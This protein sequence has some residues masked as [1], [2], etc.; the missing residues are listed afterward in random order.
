MS[1]GNGDYWNTPGAKAAEAAAKASDADAYWNAPG[2]KDA[3]HESSILAS[4]IVSINRLFRIVPRDQWTVGIGEKLDAAK[5]S[6]KVQG[7]AP[8]DIF[9]GYV[10]MSQIVYRAGR[11]WQVVIEP[12]V[13]DDE[14]IPT[15]FI[16]NCTVVW[17][18]DRSWDAWCCPWDVDTVTDTLRRYA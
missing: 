18:F 14:W 11:D 7:Y 5:K 4:T 2:V 13:L 15:K 9:D 3:I 6:A 1:N 10:R 16:Q 8:Q 12:R 17:Y